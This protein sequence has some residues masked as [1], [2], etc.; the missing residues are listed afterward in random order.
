MT[1]TE[2][3]RKIVLILVPL[4][5]AAAY[6]F[7]LLSPKREEASKLGDEL[8]QAESAR[9]D[10]VA[11]ADAVSGAKG[12]FAADFAQVLRIG[13]AIPS[14]VDMP[15]LLVQL[16]RAANGTSIGFNSIKVGQ[17]TTAQPLP[18][19]TTGDGSAPPAAA[20]G[21][22]AASAP[23]AAAE[24]A[25]DAAET[26]DQANAAAGADPATGGTATAGSAPGL[27]TVPLDFTF[28]G[29]FFELAD[30]LHR[31][32]RFVHVNNDRIVVDGR[33]MLVESFSL[34]MLQFPTL[35]ATMSTK[36][37]LSPKAEGATG[38]ATA[39]GPATAPASTPPAGSAPVPAPT[40]TA[41]PSQ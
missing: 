20:G 40:P 14:T 28:S 13:K 37:Y 33:L 24:Q 35:E 2:R 5:L 15:S 8:A 18:P 30:F 31:L 11:R 22:Q 25:N 3:D 19:A 1:L 4:V 6:W 36:V 34:K 27:D 10:A 16:D 17:R 9:D 7:L 38:G 39:A 26:S 29:D 41:A 32:K 23:G 12:N 21:Q